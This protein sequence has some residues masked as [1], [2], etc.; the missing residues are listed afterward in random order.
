MIDSSL[1]FGFLG[2]ADRFDCLL[3]L[4]ADELA[5]MPEGKIIFPVMRQVGL[6][7]KFNSPREMVDAILDRFHELRLWDYELRR[8]N[9]TCQV[10]DPVSGHLLEETADLEI[11][12]R[13][14]GNALKEV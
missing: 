2:G 5:A 7:V 1:V 12:K 11:V 3:T 14:Y 10:Y 9:G 8:V 6:E 4:A 13:K